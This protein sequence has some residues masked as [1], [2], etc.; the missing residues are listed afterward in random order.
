MDETLPFDTFWLAGFECSS[1]RRRDGRR[2]DLL[3]DTGHE[4]FAAEDYARLRR[5]GIGG[6]R[7]GVRWHLVDRGAGCYDVSTLLPLL[8]AA[9]QSGTRVIWDLCHYGWP[10]DLDIWSAEFV[11]RFARYAG[12][13]A[14][15]VCAETEG[16]A[17]YAPINEISFWS[18]AG[19]EAGY[20]NPFATG[21]GGEL[22]AQ[23]VR[24]NLAAI[25]EIWKA[26]PGARFLQAEPL[27][28]IIADPARLQDREAAV[29]LHESQYEAIE[30][31]AG[32]VRPELGGSEGVLDL[33]GVNFYPAN[34]WLLDGT[35]ISRGDPLYRPLR[36]MLAE[37]WARYRRPLLISETGVEGDSRAEWLLY[38]CR[39]VRAALKAGVPVEGICL[40]P[41]LDYPGWDDDRHCPVGLWGFPDERGERE[42]YLPV[43]RVLEV[44]GPLL[45]REWAAASRA[46][47]G[48]AA[49]SAAGGGRGVP[50]S[51]R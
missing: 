22:K 41:V 34:E 48:M 15:V 14:S 49:A 28:R 51:V 29:R 5:A 21:R 27:I 2:L 38:V 20:L 10:D 11:R 17:W 33:V 44:W 32:R 50:A 45:E 12:A 19:G 9:R 25:E 4:R 39:E 23:L 30:M 3:A 24:A 42:V 47:A 35:K 13:V 8:A 7:D 6:A 26:D 16:P 46:R 31:L 43:A 37:A 36:E 1:Q 40:Y 18:W